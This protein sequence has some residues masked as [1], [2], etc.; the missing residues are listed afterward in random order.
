MAIYDK[1]T[2][3]DAQ[4]NIN[5]LGG[6]FTWVSMILGRFLGKL[7]SEDGKKILANDPNNIKALE[8]QTARWKKVGVTEA[9]RLLC[10]VAGPRRA[11]SRQ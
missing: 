5:V 4:G 7:V 10:V 9:A 2:T 6:D 8:W 1:L 3:Y 11:L